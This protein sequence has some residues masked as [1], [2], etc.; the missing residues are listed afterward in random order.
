MTE[1]KINICGKDVCMIYCTATENNYEEMSGGK[2]ISVFVPTFKKDD[3]G[4]DIIDEPAKA[5][6][7]DYVTLALAAIVAYY[8]KKKEEMPISAEDVLF[9]TTP[10]ERNDLLSSIVELRNEWYSVT[11]IVEETIKKETEGQKAEDPKNA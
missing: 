10:S 3:N 4:N 8:S 9:E 7:G 6:I 1:K 5:T 11:K 2:S